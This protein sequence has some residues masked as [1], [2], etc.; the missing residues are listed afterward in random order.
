MDLT[1]VVTTAPA[2][3]GNSTARVGRSDPHAVTT[4]RR[5]STV[6]ALFRADGPDPC[7]RAVPTPP[8][9]SPRLCRSGRT[10]G[11]CTTGRSPSSSTW[12]ISMPAVPG[13][14]WT[15]RFDGIDLPALHLRFRSSEVSLFWVKVCHF[16]GAAQCVRSCA[17]PE[18]PTLRDAPEAVAC[19]GYGDTN[20]AD[21]HRLPKSPA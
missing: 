4:R 3:A 11:S 15:A 1:H 17:T 6:P 13:E 8:R 20:P 18:K 12:D 21:D 16:A 7:R 14:D 5:R 2:P 10:T 9:P 19:G